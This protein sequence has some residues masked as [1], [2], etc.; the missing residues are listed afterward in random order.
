MY[1]IYCKIRDLR[2][3]KDSDVAKGTGITKSTFSDW[4]SGR[5]NPK[6]EKLLKIASF[7]NV[8]VDYLMTGE[9][10][11]INETYYQNDNTQPLPR[12]LEY[13]NQLNDLGKSEATKRVEELTYFPNYTSS[14]ETDTQ[15]ISFD[16]SDVPDTFE[17][18]LKMINS[19][20][21]TNVG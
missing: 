19:P 10:K 2:G 9:E 7:L 21:D 18:K 16:L 14:D 6:R 5:S 3:F 11:E 13:Y 1:E 17:E 8:S 20:I 12:I 15:G 4:K